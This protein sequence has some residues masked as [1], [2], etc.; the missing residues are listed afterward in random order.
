MVSLNKKNA[1]Q[2]NDDFAVKLEPL[3]YREVTKSYGVELL[4]AKDLDKVNIFIKMKDGLYLS[5]FKIILYILI[6][7]IYL[8]Y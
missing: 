6:N 3:T 2:K 8:I 5:L 1:K 7:T 4:F